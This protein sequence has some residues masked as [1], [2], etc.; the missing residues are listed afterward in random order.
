[1][2]IHE[3]GATVVVTACACCYGE[4]NRYWPQVETLRFEILH[5]S[6]YL[7]R[8]LQAGLLKPTKPLDLRFTL[9]DPCHLGRRGGGV[10]DA[11]REVLSRIPGLDLV[12]M[13]RNRDEAWCC[14]AGGC[15]NLCASAAAASTAAARLSEARATGSSAMVVPSC[16]ICHN[17]FA[18]VDSQGLAVLDLCG[19]LDAT[20]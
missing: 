13:A 6:Q 2:A 10:Y 7:L 19:L 9:H 18:T 16:P 3:L 4:L 8:L 11:P 20:T 1:M 5:T 15:V 17:N 14:G 12:E